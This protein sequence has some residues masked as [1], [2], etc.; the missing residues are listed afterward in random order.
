MDL[1]LILALAAVLV[2]IGAFAMV[3]RRGHGHEGVAL[4]PEGEQRRRADSPLV[5]H[6]PAE[7]ARRRTR[8]E[9]HPAGEELVVLEDDQGLQT[10]DNI[11][12]AVNAEASSDV[13]LEALNEVSA[14]LTTDKLIEMAHEISA[15]PAGSTVA[16]ESG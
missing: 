6:H 5:P 1:T 9:R 12:P 7:E 2:A 13:L 8:H 14:A 15:D 3:L 11:I 16:D 4:E 10:V